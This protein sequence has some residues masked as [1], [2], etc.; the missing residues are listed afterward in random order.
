MTMV[1]SP[2]E[3]TIQNHS[4]VP[5][6]TGHMRAIKNSPAFTIVAECR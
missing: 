5:A 6:R 4:G 3:A 1:I 2:V